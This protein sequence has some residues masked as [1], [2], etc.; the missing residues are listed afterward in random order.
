MEIIFEDENILAVNKPAGVLTHQ[1]P[2]K[3]S[4]EETVADFLVKRFPPAG[5]VGDKP[6]ERPGIVHR[7]DRDTSGVILLAK[8]QP[9]FLYLKNLFQERKIKKTYLAVVHG[10]VKENQGMIDKPIGLKNGTIKRSVFSDKMSKPAVTFFEVL[11]RDEKNNFSVLKVAPKT[12]RTH[13]IRVHLAFLGHPVLGD[14]IYGRKG[15][16]EKNLLLHALS[17][18]FSLPRGSEIKLEADPPENLK[19]FYQHNF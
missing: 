3:E 2:G 1:I 14:K 19:K 16:Q 8:N 7:L 10:L 15:D 18:E 13:Q 17:L 9:T 12:G 6:E 4:T 11:K 5:K